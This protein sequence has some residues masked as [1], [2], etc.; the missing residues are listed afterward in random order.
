MYQN[1]IHYV[2]EAAGC[3]LEHGLAVG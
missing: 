2:G 1:E 3:W